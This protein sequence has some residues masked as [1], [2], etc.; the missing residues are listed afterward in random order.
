MSRRL[1]TLLE[2]EGEIWKVYLSFN[3]DAPPATRV[4]M[5]FERSAGGPSLRYTRM[6]DESL[7]RALHDGRP[8]SRAAL[9]EE[10]AHAVAGGK[11]MGPAD[12]RR[13]RAWRPLGEEAGP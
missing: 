2:Y 1:L 11:S 7:L 12:E 8:L 13:A 10:L 5:E 4:Q 6:P 3:G 9:R